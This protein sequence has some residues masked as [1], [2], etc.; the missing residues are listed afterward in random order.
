LKIYWSWS[1]LTISFEFLK[2]SE[3][4]PML[5]VEGKVYVKMA[6]NHR[7]ASMQPCKYRIEDKFQ[8]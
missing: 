7:L 6:A 1:G 5:H 2:K 4:L 3:E 8:N